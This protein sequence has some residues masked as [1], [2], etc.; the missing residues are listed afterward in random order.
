[1]NDVVGGDVD[2][3]AAPRLAHRQSTRDDSGVCHDAP[4]A[5]AA[6][7]AQRSS[8]TE[9]P[10]RPHSRFPPPT[11]HLADVHVACTHRSAARCRVH[12]D[13]DPVW[14]HQEES[15]TLHSH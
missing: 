9:S 10:A 5:L 1:M 7:P 14:K 3:A 11:P 6:S 4:Q 8:T 12:V 15:S 13:D 2:A